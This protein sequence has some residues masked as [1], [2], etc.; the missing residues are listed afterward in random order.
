MGTKTLKTAPLT[1]RQ[2]VD[3]LC[4]RLVE[5]WARIA[6][7]LLLASLVG[8]GILIIRPRRQ[9]RR[10]GNEP[11]PS[12]RLSRNSRNRWDCVL[13]ILGKM[14]I[15]TVTGSFKNAGMS[16]KMSKRHRW[17]Q[18]EDILEVEDTCVLQ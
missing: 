7:L 18:M 5:S 14:D 2:K 10:I 9:G 12:Q 1:W 3:V 8:L 17:E 6:L 4:H 11:M 15:S 16:A 13:Q